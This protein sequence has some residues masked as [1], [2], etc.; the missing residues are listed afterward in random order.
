MSSDIYIYIDKVFWLADEMLVT[1]II[2]IRYDYRAYTVYKP[3]LE[4]LFTNQ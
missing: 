2:M 1:L 4:P 3:L